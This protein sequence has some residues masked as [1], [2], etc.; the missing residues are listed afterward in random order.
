MSY[1][2]CGDDS[3]VYV[4]CGRMFNIHLAQGDE[5]CYELMKQNNV[6]PEYYFETE[7]ETL[8]YL[9]N[10]KQLGFRIPDRAIE[11]LQREIS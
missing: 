2:R 1:C 9:L 7:K 8:S 3:D 6:R 5:K 4:Y 10:L 11:R